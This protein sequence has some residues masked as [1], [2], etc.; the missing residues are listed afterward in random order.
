M[1]KHGMVSALALSLIIGLSAIPTLGQEE[2]GPAAKAPQEAAAP[3]AAPKEEIPQPKDLSIYGEVQAVN[4]AANSFSVQ[5]YNYDT[6][7]EKMI[8]VLVDKD[9]KM[10]NAASLNE[11]KKGDWADV[12]YVV[13]AGKNIVKSMIVEKEEVD[14]GEPAPQKE[15][16]D[17]AAPDEG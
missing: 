7:E 9:T 3:A 4:A 6:D 13:D 15:P 16:P 2:P 12:T 8:E 5:Y 10:E 14:A 11:I 1:R 17:M